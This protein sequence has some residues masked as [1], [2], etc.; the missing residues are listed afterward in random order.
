MHFPLTFPFRMYVPCHIHIGSR[1][2]GLCSYSCNSFSPPPSLFVV[3]LFS[4]VCQDV[5]AYFCFLPIVIALDY[6]SVFVQK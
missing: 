6:N 1:G 2:S 4:H 3:V 5:S